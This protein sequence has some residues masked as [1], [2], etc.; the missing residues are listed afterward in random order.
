MF[1]D[2]GVHTSYAGAELNARC[3]LEGL[4]SLA[5]NPLQ[6]FVLVDE[7]PAKFSEPGAAK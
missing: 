6:A 4:N 3:V 1:A 2:R 5:K 7:T